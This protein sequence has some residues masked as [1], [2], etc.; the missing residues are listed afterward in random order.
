MSPVEVTIVFQTAAGSGTIEIIDGKLTAAE[1]RS[2]DGSVQPVVTGFDINSAS[3]LCLKILAAERGEAATIARIKGTKHPFSFLVRDASREHPII[4]PEYGVAVTAGD[5]TRSFEELLEA[6]RSRGLRTKLDSIANDVEESFASAAAATRELKCPMWLGVSRDVRI[7]EFNLRGAMQVTDTIQPRFHGYGYFWP[8]PD[9]QLLPSKYGFVAGRGWGPTED[10][11]RSLD[12]GCLPILRMK[13]IDDDIRYDITLFTT[14]EVQH[15]TEATLRG[16]DA[17]VADGLSVCHA[18]T[19][20]QQKRFESIR[21]SELSTKEEIILCGRVVAT[22]T[23][24]VPRYAFFKA[25]HPVFGMYGSPAE[26]T[27]DGSTGL[28]GYADTGLAFGVSMLNGK[29]LPRE[30]L[31]VLV[32]PGESITYDFVLPHRPVSKSRAIAMSKLDLGGLLDQCREFW[33]NKLSRCAQITLP[34]KRIEDSLLAGFLHFDLT[35]YGHEPGGP[36]NGTNGVYSALGSETTT[37]ILFLDSIGRHD[38]AERNLAYF[39]SKQ[40][41]NGLIQNFDGYML[42]TGAILW[43]ADEH[44]RMSGD[45]S[46]IER[47]RSSITRAA[48][49][50][51]QWRSEHKLEDLRG[52]GF[53]LVPGRVADPLDEQRIFMLNGYS[54]LGLARTAELLRENLPSDAARYQKE[55]E[56]YRSDIRDALFAELASGPVIPAG[57]GTWVPTVGPWVGAGGPAGLLLSGKPRWS[58]GAFMLPDDL[59][60]P[61]HLV[62]QEVLDPGEPAVD[63]LLKFYSEL[64]Y[65]RNF[66]FSQPYY[67][68]HPWV[69]LKRRETSAFLKA[70]YTGLASLADRETGSWWEHFFHVSAHKTHEEGNYL[71]QTRWALWLEEQ[72]QLSLLRGIPRAW[73][74]SGSQIRLENVASYFGPFSLRV[75]S[76]GSSIVGVITCSTDRKPKRIEVRLPQ[77]DRKKVKRV[78]GGTFDAATECILISNFTGEARFQ[79]H[80]QD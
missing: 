19:E 21:E 80:F 17:M 72:D 77:P 26:H 28:S 10:V 69:H 64:F 57:D 68:R 48:D 6:V 14:L 45:Q 44:V 25:I 52:K 60:G 32:A 31:A 66:P 71:M 16:T 76:H 67:S 33:H 20:E 35:S 30:E 22:N 73:M 13:R 61:M 39:F 74:K 65:S 8:E 23:A 59:L 75:D 56:S 47:H 2:A 7:F 50:L 3:R 34:E 46:F 29:P 79:L 41:E 38:L 40:R 43:C 37:N 51:I 5:D 49:F 9:K 70:W 42:E 63:L 27:F 62:F 78:E 15:L 55:A 58:H 11:S 12:D 18:F 36:L 54:Y 1:V 53:G 24:S 4:I